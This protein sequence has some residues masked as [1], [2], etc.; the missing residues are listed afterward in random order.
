M[1]CII[2]LKM[3][4]IGEKRIGEWNIDPFLPIQGRM[5]RPRYIDLCIE[6]SKDTLMIQRQWNQADLFNSGKTLFTPLGTFL[7]PTKETK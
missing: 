1:E 7:P 4:K 5:V 6:L 3:K 2:S